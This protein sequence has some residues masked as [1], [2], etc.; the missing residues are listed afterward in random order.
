MA[1]PIQPMRHMEN[2]IEGNEQGMR[3]KPAI[4]TNDSAKQEMAVELMMQ[5]FSKE[6]ICRILNISP[7]Q[8]PEQLPF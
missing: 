1:Q 3:E 4:N 8:L 6:V 5:G 2:I 7:D